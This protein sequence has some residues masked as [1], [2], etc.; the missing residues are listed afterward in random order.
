MAPQ[1][2]QVLYPKM[3]KSPPF[4]VEAAGYEKHEGETIPRRHPQAKEKLLTKPSDDVSTVYENF[5]RS[6]AKFGNAKALGTRK[7]IKT[8]TENKKV[9]KVVDGQETE[10]DKKWTYYELSGY[11]YLSFVEYEKL[12]LDCGSGLRHLGM[13]KDDKIHL[14]G[15]TRYEKTTSIRKLLS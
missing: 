11:S 7:L 12:A 13:E 3:T 5:R 10:V 14:Y 4:S 15:A 9:K 8:H 1:A 2:G 6:A